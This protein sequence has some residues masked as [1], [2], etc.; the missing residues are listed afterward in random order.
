MWLLV[1]RVPP[2]ATSC[3]FRNGTPVPITVDA[4]NCGTGFVGSPSSRTP[5]DFGT[6]KICFGVVDIRNLNA[7]FDR[8]E[9]MSVG[10]ERSVGEAACTTAGTAGTAAV[11]VKRA[12]D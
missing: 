3:R 11:A 12:R 4:A 6:K 7:R 1:V 2:T 5:P 10:T 8:T 9:K